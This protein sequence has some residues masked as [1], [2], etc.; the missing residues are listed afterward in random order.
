[1]SHV[2]S[3]RYDFEREKL[4]STCANNVNK[5]HEKAKTSNGLIIP[6]MDTMN[7]WFILRHFHFQM[8]IN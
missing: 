7:M 2:S 4:R 5:F 8:Y 1:M 6:V 3:A